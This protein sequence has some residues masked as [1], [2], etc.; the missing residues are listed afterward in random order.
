MTIPILYCYK[1]VNAALFPPPP[2]RDNQQKRE[3][4]SLT[5]T[6]KNRSP[7][8]PSASSTFIVILAICAL[9]S[10]FITAFQCD[11]PIYANIREIGR[12]NVKPVCLN[13]VDLAVGFNV[14]H[15]ISDACL[16]VVPFLMLWRVQMK[17][18]TKLKVCIA[19]VIGFS[20]VGLAIGRTVAQATARQQPGFDLTCMPL[21]FSHPCFRSYLSFPRFCLS[22]KLAFNPT[23]F[24]VQIPLPLHLPTR[25]RN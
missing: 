2:P 14:W 9:V 16:L 5:P 21:P 18:T 12:R 3:R 17:W 7:P 23:L 24:I 20:N 1:L 10:V 4:R 8:P 11:P 6:P 22:L 19:G 13:I 15:I 25:P